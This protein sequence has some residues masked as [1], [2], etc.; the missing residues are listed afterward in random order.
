MTCIVYVWLVVDTRNFVQSLLDG[1][2][3][4]QIV[5]DSN[6][7]NVFF[8]YSRQTAMAGYGNADYN[9]SAQQQQPN[10]QQQQSFNFDMPEQFGNEL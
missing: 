7:E 9:W 4:Q 8:K 1:V 5:L 3:Y 2:H 10:Q 6:W